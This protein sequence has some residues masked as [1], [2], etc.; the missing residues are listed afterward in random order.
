MPVIAALTGDRF[1]DTWL[2]P[3]DGLALSLQPDGEILAI[4]RGVSVVTEA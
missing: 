1:A 4:W 3:L 2:E